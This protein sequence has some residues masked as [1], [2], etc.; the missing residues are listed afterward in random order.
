MQKRDYSN[1]D[2]EDALRRAFVDNGLKS[3]LLDGHEAKNPFKV[4]GINYGIKRGWL[5][6]ED[7]IKESQYTAVTY[8]L[9]NKGK[10]YFGLNK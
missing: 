6:K 3:I 4:D 10:E 2:L 8:V 7:D 1:K 9:T 5:R